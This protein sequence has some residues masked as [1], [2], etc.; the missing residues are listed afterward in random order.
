MNVGVRSV[1]RACSQDN[2]GCYSTMTKSEDGQT[3][4]MERA[5]FVGNHDRTGEPSDT[6]D[7]VLPGHFAHPRQVGYGN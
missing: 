6:R 3:R 4:R 7:D 1:L 5:A 2:S